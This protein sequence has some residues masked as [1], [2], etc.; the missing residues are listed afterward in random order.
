MADAN[1]RNYTPFWIIV[2][3]LLLILGTLVLFRDVLTGGERASQDVQPPS[4]EWTTAPEGGVEVN[5]PETPIR[6]VRPESD[7]PAENASNDEE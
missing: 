4:D 5:L 2:I 1:K 6:A 7:S 3:V